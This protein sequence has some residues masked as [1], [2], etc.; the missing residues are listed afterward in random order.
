M[1][2]LRLILLPPVA[3]SRLTLPYIRRYR[4]IYVGVDI[5]ACFLFSGGFII[6]CFHVCQ[7]TTLTLDT[8]TLLIEQVPFLVGVELHPGVDNQ[9]MPGTAAGEELMPVSCAGK[10]HVTK[11]F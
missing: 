5:H 7:D 11:F 6:T 4:H 9:C 10:G 2:G 1:A 3:G 8:D